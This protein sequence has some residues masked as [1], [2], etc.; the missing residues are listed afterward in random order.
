MEMDKFPTGQPEIMS[1]ADLLAQLDALEQA[2]HP[3]DFAPAADSAPDSI[4]ISQVKAVGLLRSL[5]ST[6]TAHPPDDRL[7]GK[8]LSATHRKTGNRPTAVR[9]HAPAANT[10]PQ[11]QRRHD[12][13]AS[14]RSPCHA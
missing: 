10:Q 2:A 3:E 13:A 11:T 14:N 9:G 7:T 5:S 12:L 4:T 1:G 8:P 6:I